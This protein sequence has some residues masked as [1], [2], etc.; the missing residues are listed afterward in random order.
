MRKSK[1]KA[2][3]KT[4]TS[5]NVATSKFNPADPMVRSDALKIIQKSKKNGI[6]L[7]ILASKLHTTLKNAKEV[8][9]QLSFYDG[10]NIVP[11]GDV[12]FLSDVTPPIDALNIKIAKGKEIKIGVLSDTHI[13]S[14]HE[15]LDVL[16]A[17]Y[18][19]YA[20]E[21]IT[22]VFHAGNIIDGEFKF[23]RYELHAHG[24]HDQ[25][26]YLADHY[27]QRDGMTTYYITGDCHEGWWQKDIGLNIGWYM[28]RWCEDSGR[29]DL[30][31]IGHLE[32]DVLFEQP[33]GT[34]RLRI[35]HPGGGTP[36]AIS[37]PSQKMVES[38]QG[39]DKPH[40]LI[41]GHFHKFDMSYP[42]EVLTIMPGC[43]QDQTSF[44]RKKK[45]SAHVGFC[46]VTLGARVDGTLGQA[47]CTFYPFYDRSYHQKLNGYV[48]GE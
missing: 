34:F 24:V 38:F 25:C 43:V 37:Y 44:M 17:A 46:V 48:I 28:Q 5:K 45:L 30:V 29:N 26:A 19:L 2:G 1:I 32:Q 33:H 22:Q 6:T 9:S 35:I 13:C 39:G 3:C 41:M 11:Q 31:H 18:D 15:R 47:N 16:E 7:E 21:G 42:R 23:N 4:S 20:K 40:A 27:P 10:F 36:Y 14:Y 12:Y 8:L